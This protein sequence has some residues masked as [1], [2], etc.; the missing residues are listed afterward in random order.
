MAAVIANRARNARAP[1]L[2]QAALACLPGATP[3]SLRTI[4]LGVRSVSAVCRFSVAAGERDY[5]KVLRLRHVAY[6]GID[7]IA[8]TEPIHVM[9]DQYDRRAEI[10]VAWH[11]R[12]AVGS[13]RV[14][15]PKENDTHEF[16][17]L[18]PIPTV[19]GNRAEL[20]VVSRICTHPLYRGADLFAELMVYC[21]RAILHHGRR[22]AFGGC[23]ENLVPLYER[24][25]WE[26]IG[27][28]YFHPTLRGG[29]EQMIAKIVSHRDG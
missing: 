25:G 12:E 17:N 1:W 22:I 5:E 28:E 24:F 9:A 7:R 4:G 13:F 6:S 21:D 11:R 23:A 8:A 26:T 16:E 27:V 19:F 3:A 15:F 10:W 2:G 20:G 14:A 29:R 18:A